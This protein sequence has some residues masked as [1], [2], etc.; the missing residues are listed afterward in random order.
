MVLIGEQMKKT[1]FCFTQEN[2]FEKSQMTTKR[3]KTTVQVKTT[4]DTGSTESKKSE[5]LTL[6]METE[7]FILYYSDKDKA[8]LQDLSK[9]LESGYDKVT[10]DL[11]CKL[12]GKTTVEI[13]PDTETYHKAIGKPDAPGWYVGEGL[14]A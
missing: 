11:N 7:H 2:K 6:N 8:L 4:A 13:Y 5:T 9:A 3:L 10:K 14:G 1:I 12:D